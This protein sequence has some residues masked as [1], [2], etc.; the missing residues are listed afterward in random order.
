[1]SR[2][3]PSEDQKWAGRQKP[4]RSNVNS[5]PE[6]KRSVPVPRQWR[7]KVA[8]SASVSA[9]RTTTVPS[10]ELAWRRPKTQRPSADSPIASKL[11]SFSQRRTA[12]TSLPD[13][14]RSSRAKKPDRLQTRSP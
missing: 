14:R 4:L 13:S 10:R 8:T 7:V 9:S 6:A 11:K 2:G 3:C 12:S 1:M 5:A